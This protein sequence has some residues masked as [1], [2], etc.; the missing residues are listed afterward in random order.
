MW[1]AKEGYLGVLRYLV[2]Q[3]MDKDKTDNHGRSTLMLVASEGHLECYSTLWS[4]TR[5]RT[6]PATMAGL[7]SWLQPAAVTLGW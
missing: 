7:L 5:T 2:E 3:G 4:K 6:K 1:A